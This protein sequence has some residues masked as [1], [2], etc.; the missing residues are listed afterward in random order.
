MSVPTTAKKAPTEADIRQAAQV[1]QQQPNNSPKQFNQVVSALSLLY[2]SGVLTSMVPALPFMLR[3]KGQPYSLH[4]H[5]PME[6]MFS[7]VMPHEFVVKAGRQVSK[8]LKAGDFCRLANGRLIAVQDL[9]PG[10]YISSVD[11]SFKFSAQKIIRVYD[12]GVQKVQRVR[13][14][15]G[16]EFSITPN[17][18]LQTLYKYSPLAELHTGS[19]VAAL[20]S[21]NWFHNKQIPKAR[22]AITAYMLGDGCIG[23][24]G[25]FA[26]TS[27][28]VDIQ[29]EFTKLC[30]EVGNKP[31]VEYRNGS[32]QQLN[33][34]RTGTIRN[35]FVEDNLWKQGSATK[36][37]PPWVFDLSLAD[38]RLFV[39]R[40]WSTGGCIKRV[41]AGFPS[42][43]YTSVSERLSKDT[44][45]LLLKFGILSSVNRRKTSCDG[46]RGKDAFIVRVET[47]NSQ[48]KFLSIFDVP[49]KPSIALLVAKSNNNRDTVPIELTTM[50]R[51]LALPTKYA[52]TGTKQATDCLYSHG[53]RHTLRYPLSKHKLAS[54]IDYFDKHSECDESSIQ[55]LKN[56]QNADITWDTITSIKPDG[57]HRTYDI[58][59]EGTH[60]YVINSVVSHNST[61]LAAQGIAQATLNNHFSSLFVCPRFE[62]TRRFSNNYVKTFLNESPIGKAKLDQSVKPSVL[63]RTFTNGSM[64]HFSYAFLDCERIRGI[65]ADLVRYD[66]V[67][68]I[69]PD[70]IPVIN[71]TLSASNWDLR[72]YTGTPKTLDN[73]LQFLWEKS[74]QSEWGIPC[75]CK[76]PNRFWNIASVNEQLLDMIQKDGLSC[77]NC[78]KLL[79]AHNGRWIPAFEDLLP[80]FPG[81]HVP[82]PIMP[83]HYEPN[84][85]SGRKDKW[86]VLWDAKNTMGKTP[87]WNEKLGEACDVRVSLLTKRDL[88]AQSDPSRVN[89][90]QKAMALRDQYIDCII[91]V[92]WGGGGISNI[93]YTTV[94]ILGFKPGGNID[95]LYGERLMDCADSGEEVGIILKYMRA[96]R[97]SLIAHDF[98]GA[99]AVKE[100]L[101]IQAGLG[102]GRIFPAVYMRATAANMVTYKSPSD[103]RGGRSYYVIDKARSL[104]LLCELIKHGLF[105]F[106]EYESWAR[107]SNDL[108]ALTEE[109][110]EMPRGGDVFLVTRKASQSDDFA[111]SINFAALAYWHANQRFPNLASRL[112]I[113]LNSQQEA[114]ELGQE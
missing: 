10:M 39:S 37:V 111:H 3:L 49:G 91:G 6:P 66:E 87:L 42:I 25:N 53:L 72:Q 34:S 47:R 54:Y 92:D 77:A 36:F 41:A 29:K 58:E 35:W 104:V 83:R 14:R 112:G 15:L 63:Q 44:Q 11:K 12:N 93:S 5:F 103:T 78:G 43:T 79:D 76:S 70:F 50:L 19:R 106:P 113:R 23:L 55:F 4:N 105:K 65:A 18:K 2:G 32:T 73:T 85:I 102:T 59:V 7:L 114:D 108:L 94:A 38:T 96:F 60:S 27:E 20:N 30:T 67:Q 98:N 1:L 31:R 26:L 74:S 62:Q 57:K 21:G 8:C 109:R 101:L 64:M 95:V 16:S 28:T 61:S 68:D 110:H 86:A 48:A 22:I 69:D 24:S 71:E 56:L 17:H 80:T 81:F 33:L 107:L 75:D 99:G 9:Q 52:G 84:P 97:C 100:T 40:L 88:Q 90:L 82:Q 13:T 46:K 51:K 89:D 45:S